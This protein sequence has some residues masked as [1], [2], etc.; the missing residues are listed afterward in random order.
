MNKMI[1]ILVKDCVKQIFFCF[2]KKHLKGLFFNTT[3]TLIL[4]TSKNYAFK[5]FQCFIFKD[6]L[7]RIVI[8]VSEKCKLEIIS[9]FDRENA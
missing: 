5:N 4:T 7:G 8:T 1:I 3:I 2:V 9:L 6:W